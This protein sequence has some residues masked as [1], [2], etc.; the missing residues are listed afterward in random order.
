MELYFL[1]RGGINSRV[2]AAAF[3]YKLSNMANKYDDGK[4]VSFGFHSIETERASDGENIVILWLDEP[5]KEV[6]GSQ[7]VYLPDPDGRCALVTA[8]NV[9]EI[10]IMEKDIPEGNSWCDFDPSSQRG[11]M[12]VGKLVL[13]VAKRS[14]QVWLRK[15]PFRMEAERFL[16]RMREGRVAELVREVRDLKE[17]NEH[18]SKQLQEYITTCRGVRFENILKDSKI[19]GLEKD[20][21]MLGD[22]VDELMVEN[23]R[24]EHDKIIQETRPLE[25]QTWYEDKIKRLEEELRMEKDVSENHRSIA[26][27]LGKKLND[28]QGILGRE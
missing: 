12:T 7:T 21:K 22:K 13:D 24:L 23:R 8:R 3:F 1:T 4:L 15:R 6:I 17:Q 2:I 11:E 28:I 9:R 18:L 19:K 25:L 10:R 20:V 5:L 14:H 26:E 16:N 27:G